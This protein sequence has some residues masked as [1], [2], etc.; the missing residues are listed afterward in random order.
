MEWLEEHRYQ[1]IMVADVLWV[2]FV[3]D[4]LAV[5]PKT[6]DLN[7]KLH[8]LNA[9][10]PHIQF[11]LKTEKHGSIPFLDCEIV[12]DGSQAK[13]KVYRKPTNREDYV[14]FFS[15]HNDRVKSG[16]VLVFFLR[17][18]L[19]CSAEYLDDEIQH[20]ISSFMRLQYPKGFLL[21]LKKKACEIRNKTRNERRRKKEMRYISIPKL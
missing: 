15:S 16:I 4:M 21:H 6:T 9:V 13:F 20:I 10:E 1:Q 8:E 7:A 14:H 5:A 11:T 3:D 19:I 18:M 2:R 17:A 12:R